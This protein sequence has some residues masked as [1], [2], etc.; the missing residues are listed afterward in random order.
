MNLEI[1][2]N[3]QGTQNNGKKTVVMSADFFLYILPGFVYI[4]MLNLNYN[5]INL[6][7]EKKSKAK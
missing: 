1:S 3:L 2:P 5:Q 7:R 6:V 4:K